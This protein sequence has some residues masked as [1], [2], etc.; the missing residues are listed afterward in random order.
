MPDP[1]GCVFQ[2]FKTPR[3][4]ASTPG[5]IASVVVLSPTIVCDVGAVPDVAPFAL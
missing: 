3:V 1:S 5:F 2:P 4:I